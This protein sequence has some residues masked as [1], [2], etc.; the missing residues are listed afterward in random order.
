MIDIADSLIPCGFR[1]HARDSEI[2]RGEAGR[3]P[4]LGKQ[5]IDKFSNIVW[6]VKA[7]ALLPASAFLEATV[8]VVVTDGD[9]CSSVRLCYLD[10]R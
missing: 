8:A 10:F 5:V 2:R 4:G 6:I 7:G 3:R 9:V 1:R